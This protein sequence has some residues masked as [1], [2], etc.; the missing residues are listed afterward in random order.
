MKNGSKTRSAAASLIPGPSSL[1][2][3]RTAPF[4]RTADTTTP[5]PD[6]VWVSALSMRIR[7]T[8]ATRSGSQTASIRSPPRRTSSVDSCLSS[9]GAN[10]AVTARVSSPRSVGSGRSS[11]E[12]ASRRERS[13]R[14]VASLP[15]RSTCSRTRRDE[16]APRLLVELLVL[17][18]LQEAADR[19]DR[20]AQLVRR[21][22]DEAPPRALE[23]G[24][25]AL[26]VVQRAR[27]LAELVVLVDRE[28][29]GEVAARDLAGA[30]LERPHAARH[31]ARDDEAAGE[32]EQQP[33]RAGDEDL[34]ADQARR[35]PARRPSAPRRRA[36]RLTVPSSRIGTA[37]WPSSPSRDGLA[38][39][40][41]AAG[42]RRDVGD[43]E[44]AGRGC[45][46][47]V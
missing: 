6:G 38:A 23:L 11:S 16:L 17:H 28:D 12:P 2:A 41:H 1:T 8:C 31:R 14:S 37:T 39:D 9:A 30:A 34:A 4:S 46:F 33:E 29:R 7:R 21:G 18:E 19:E 27:E 13:S 32:R 43:L 20:R 10:S 47:S 35:C 40:R 36:T 3:S 22:R 42:A 5:V 25:L 24:E 26:H 45:A 44:V 15:R